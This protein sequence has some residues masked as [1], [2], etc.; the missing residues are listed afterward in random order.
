MF[1]N[2]YIFVSETHRLKIFISGKDIHVCTKKGKNVHDTS[3]TFKNVYV[4]I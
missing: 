1:V 4:V 3:L 2:I